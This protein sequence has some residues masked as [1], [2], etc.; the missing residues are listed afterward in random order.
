MIIADKTEERTTVFPQPISHASLCPS[1]CPILERL[2]RNLNFKTRK[3][4]FQKRGF[5]AAAEARNQESRGLRDCGLALGKLPRDRK[6]GQEYSHENT[7]AGEV[8]RRHHSRRVRST[9]TDRC[10][11][12]PAKRHTLPEEPHSRRRIRLREKSHTPGEESHAE[13]KIGERPTIHVPHVAHMA[14]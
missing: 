3:F 14:A 5:G 1:L 11:T 12:P 7:S 4:C 8:H 2:P 9:T 6:N 10:Y 13:G